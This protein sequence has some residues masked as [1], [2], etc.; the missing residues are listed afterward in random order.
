[1][2]CHVNSVWTDEQSNMLADLLAEGR[3]FSQIAAAINE[4]FSTNYSRNAICGKGFRL[5]LKALPK[6]RAK[7]KAPPRPKRTAPATITVR[8]PTREAIE[9]RC[10]EIEPRH[11]TIDQLGPRDCRY[12][13]GEGPFTFCGHA[14]HGDSSY[15]VSHDRLCHGSAPKVSA[16]EVQRRRLH[17][18][19]LQGLATIFPMEAAE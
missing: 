9:I 10:A 11:L 3:S 6:V 15:C 18:K 16:L 12:P 2:G 4:Q 14:Q 5:N 13:Y 19:K 8:Q 7:P 1:M 17:W